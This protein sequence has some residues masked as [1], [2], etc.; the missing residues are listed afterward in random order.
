LQ[1]NFAGPDGN[2]QG[3]SFWGRR[4]KPDLSRISVIRFLTAQPILGGLHHRYA[5]I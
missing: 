3:D 4:E 5:R 2:P 1:F